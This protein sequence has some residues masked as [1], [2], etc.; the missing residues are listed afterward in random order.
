MV[1]RI[2]LFYNCARQAL[3]PFDVR[4]SRTIWLDDTTV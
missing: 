2:K 1:S 3:V 4:P